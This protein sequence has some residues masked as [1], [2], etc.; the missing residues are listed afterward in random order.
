MSRLLIRLYLPSAIPRPA[1]GAHLNHAIVFPG[2]SYGPVLLR[3][4]YGTRV[5]YVHM[6]SCR[7][8][9]MA[10]G[11]CQGQVNATLLVGSC[12]QHLSEII[13]SLRR[14]LPG[15]TTRRIL[16]AAPF[17]PHRKT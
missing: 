10:A 14:V 7:T 11:A 2:G 16:F 6:L 15:F 1:L 3:A 5:F 13:F 17:P 9:I 4:G 12:R 8:Q